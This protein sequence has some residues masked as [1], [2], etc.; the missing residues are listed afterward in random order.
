MKRFLYCILLGV[1]SIHTNGQNLEQVYTSNGS[2]YEGYISEQIPG[3]AIS[4]Y[5]EKVQL[6]LPTKDIKNLREDFRA[7]ANFGNDVADFAASMQEEV[8]GFIKLY[9]FEYNGQYYDHMFV[10]AKNDISTTVVSFD[11]KTYN[12]SWKDVVR[13]TKTVNSIT[14]YGL[15]DI[16]TLVTGE[17]NEGFIYEQI[18]GQDISFESV[19]GTRTSY[20]VKDVLSTRVEPIDKE[21]DIWKQT[22][23]L[24][25]IEIEGK[26][27]VEGV[28]VSRVSGKRLIILAKD[29]Y[30]QSYD[31]AEITKYQKTINN[32]F[33]E[34]VPPVIE[35]ELK[36]TTVL[37]CVND[38]VAVACTPTNQNEYYFLTDANVVNVKAGEMVSIQLKNVECDKTVSLYATKSQP[39][40]SKEGHKKYP[41]FISNAD[42]IFECNTV[43]NDGLIKIDYKIRKKGTYFLALK[44]MEKGVVIVAE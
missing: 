40:S 43:E 18:I 44:G 42:P 7:V 23:L 8:N 3:K 38:S 13:T 19:D 28:I 20:A 29:G 27:V 5:V 21:I 32:E 31:L 11:R 4:V 17:R 16:I 34:Y 24:D 6:V 12:L 9:S 35:A 37:I 14:P 33:E 41:A 30:D 25:R 22:P 10:T 39:M 36:D 26:R 15:K 1:L 2:V